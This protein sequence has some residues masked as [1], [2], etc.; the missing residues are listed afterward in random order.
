M[1]VGVPAQV[2]AV[3]EPR[4]G[5][6]VVESRGTRRTVDAGLFAEDDPLTVGDWVLVHMGVAM[7]RIDEAESSEISGL[8]EQTAP[9][10][11]AE[12]VPPGFFDSDV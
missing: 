6:V 9:E 8:L 3:D 1:C 4:A 10:P 11:A 2:V 12:A 5:M 7:E